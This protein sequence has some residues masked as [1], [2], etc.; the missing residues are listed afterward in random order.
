MKG[1]FFFII[2]AIVLTACADGPSGRHAP[3]VLTA[4]DS[5]HQMVIQYCSG[6][7][8]PVQPDILDKKTWKNMVLPAMAEKM[9]IKVW[10]GNQYYPATGN[11]QPQISF[12]EWT[13]LVEYFDHA[14]P[15]SI[16]VSR[17]ADSLVTDWF[18][19]SLQKP[20]LQVTEK[21]STMMV[22]FDSISHK[23]FTADNDNHLFQWTS[24]LK[25][26]QVH[27]LASPAVNVEF[28]KEVNGGSTGIFTLIGTM[29]AVDQ[30]LGELVSFTVGDTA[31][32]PLILADKV[33]RPIH[34]VSGDFDKDGLEDWLVCGFGHESGALYLA[35]QNADGSFSKTVLRDVPGAT[36]SITGDFNGD[37]WLDF[38]CLFAHADEGI[39]LFTN[40][41]KGG[42][43]AENVLRFPPYYG[44]TSFQLVDFNQDGRL[45]ILY[46]CG[47]NS[48]Y[49]RI[50]KREHG[51]YIFLNEGGDKFRQAWFY[52]VNGSTKAVAA[53]FN[54]DGLM[55]IATIAFFADLKNNPSEKFIC[56]EQKGPL[57]FKAHALPIAKAGRWICM[58]VKDLDHDGDQDVILGNYSR[59]FI[60]QPG[61]EPG[62][63]MYTP[64]VVLENGFV[65]KKR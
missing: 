27:R 19:F 44:S 11:A 50:L 26:E 25:K 43:N 63:D 5:G 38:Y 59:G 42:F 56:F 62:W 31:S 64:F 36:Q 55:D 49:S 14:A 57:Q 46:T 28:K 35:H 22:S 54:R 45:D 16:P 24:R 9:G 4:F 3:Q 15:D 34:S 21:A 2:V 18:V 6:C 41:K 30:S 60:N 7:H 61:F 65:R 10:N 32:K 53:D 20:L 47:D 29:Q 51:V 12:S 58:D 33:P 1:V 8:L 23:I 17:S 40:D 39:W 52:H 48:D 37:G 13:R